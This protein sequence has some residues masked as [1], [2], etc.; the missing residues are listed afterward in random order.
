MCVSRLMSILL[1]GSVKSG[2]VGTEQ[3][4]RDQENKTTS[5]SSLACPPPHPEIIDS[6][7]IIWNGEWYFAKNQI[8]SKPFVYRRVSD[9]V[10]RNIINYVS[11]TSSSSH[12]NSKPRAKKKLKSKESS[13]KSDSQ[14]DWYVNFLSHFVMAIVLDLKHLTLTIMK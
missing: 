3:G 13:E 1:I 2:D 4:E 10:P 12:S 11:F 8:N 14:P 9:S 5:P 6:T 7:E